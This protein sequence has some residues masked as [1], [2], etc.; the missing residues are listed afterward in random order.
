MRGGR[1]LVL[2]VVAAVAFTACGGGGKHGGGSSQGSP[3]TVPTSVTPNPQGSAPATTGETGTGLADAHGIVVFSCGQSLTFRVLDPD[4][5]HVV[6]SATGNMGDTGQA[7]DNCGTFTQ[8]FPARISQPVKT[9]EQFDR[10][11]THWVT[12]DAAP[13]GAHVVAL[14]DLATGTHRRLAGGDSGEF[15]ARPNRAIPLFS[16][17]DQQVCF[18]DPNPAKPTQHIVCTDPAS[19]VTT[20]IDDHAIHDADA[21][22]F[23]LL[24]T[25]NFAIAPGAR[26]I[27]ALP[28][29][30]GH[31]LPNASGTD[32]EQDLTL[33]G[34]APG[35]NCTVGTWVDDHRLICMPSEPHPTELYLVTLKPDFSILTAT[36]LLPPTDFA[37][38]DAVVSPDSTRVA[39][40]AERTGERVLFVAQL[41]GGGVPRKVAD[42]PTDPPMVAA[43]AWR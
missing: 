36:S 39:F 9:T 15:D 16:P 25:T 14:V 41:K 7:V 8:D 1:S 31:G 38:I 35:Q 43:L 5:G 27:F 21:G 11:F 13:D 30:F 33:P 24:P 18:Y 23:S 26:T 3:A 29:G 34:S 42:V 6:R 22:W 32:I 17:S 2:A 19:G 37:I 12:V 20:P 4:D 10:D 28:S 40:V